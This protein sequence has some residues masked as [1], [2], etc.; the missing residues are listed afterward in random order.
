MI[1]HCMLC[2]EPTGKAGRDDDSFYYDNVFSRLEAAAGLAIA[3]DELM[4]W[5]E[6]DE[7]T[8]PAKLQPIRAALRQYR[9]ATK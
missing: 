3:I 9:E 2:D 5:L 4:E 6:D 1:E 7:Y 8:P